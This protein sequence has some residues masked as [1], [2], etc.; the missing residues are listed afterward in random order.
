MNRSLLAFVAALLVTG[1]ALADLR[2]SQHTLQPVT[3][4]SMVVMDRGSKLEVLATERAMAA[5]DRSGARVLQR[6]VVA[7]SDAPI[8]PNQLGVVFNHAMQ[9]HGYITGEITFKVKA[10][11]ALTTQSSQLYPG[12]KLIVAPSVYAINTRTPAEFIR[13][14]KRLQG[15]TDL[16]WVEPT[17]TYEAAVAPAGTPAAQ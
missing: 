14:L 5:V 9:A 8:S 15:S 2:P 17:V 7:S 11:R 4:P 16:L 10:G 1:A 3:D 13:V 6:K 12:L